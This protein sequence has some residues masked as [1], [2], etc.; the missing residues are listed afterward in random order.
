MRGQSRR[1]RFVKVFISRR[2]SRC[3]KLKFFESILFSC[4]SF[5]VLTKNG[6]RRNVCFLKETQ[7]FRFQGQVLK[8]KASKSIVTSELL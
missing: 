3:V 6:H 1:F 2:V 4:S 5:C 8:K 7:M